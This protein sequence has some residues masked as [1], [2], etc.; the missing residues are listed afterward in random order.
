M[1]KVAMIGAGSA[2]FSL[3]IISDF[4]KIPEFEDVEIYLMDID[5]TRLN[6]TFILAN[7]LS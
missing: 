5:E 4:T 7:K 1:F 3:R 2:I 6:S